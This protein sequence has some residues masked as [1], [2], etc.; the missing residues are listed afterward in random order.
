[1]E[2][3]S[4]KAMVYKEYGT[5][6]NLEYLD[7]PKPRPMDGEVLI[8][9][10]AA[11]LNWIDWHFLSGTPFM[12]RLMAGLTEPKNNILGIDFAG[13]VDAVFENNSVADV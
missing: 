8:K 12:V 13:I 3:F 1:M 10:K 9:L 4:M 6:R 11:S 7:L 5:P 2:D